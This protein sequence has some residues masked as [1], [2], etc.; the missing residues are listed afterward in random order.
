MKRRWTR[1]LK[2][3]LYGKLV[4]SFCT[5][6]L[7][8]SAVALDSVCRRVHSVLPC[9]CAELSQRGVGSLMFLAVHF[10]GPPPYIFAIV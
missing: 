3:Q 2:R 4:L 8:T 5:K 6:S 1:C 7:R 10:C 9:H